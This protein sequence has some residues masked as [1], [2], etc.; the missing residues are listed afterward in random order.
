M[1]GICFRCA[2]GS[3]KGHIIQNFDELDEK[4]FNELTDNFERQIQTLV[5]KA[6]SILEKA[7][8]QEKRS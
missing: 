6:E 2:I 1:G 7:E 8:N 4:T 3:H 5:E